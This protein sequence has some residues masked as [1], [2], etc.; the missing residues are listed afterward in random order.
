M[1]RRTHQCKACDS[2]AEFDIDLYVRSVELGGRSME[3]N[4]ESTMRCCNNHRQ[5]ME[6]VL[7]H[8]SNRSLFDAM[9]KAEGLPPADWKTAK[10]VFKPIP[11]E[12]SVLHIDTTQLIPQCDFGDEKARCV[13][14]AKYQIALRCFRIGSK[15]DHADILI[16]KCTCE[17]H[18]RVLK[19]EHILADNASK[20]VVLV[21][22]TNRG[23]PMPDFKR[24]E[25]TFHIMSRGRKI[26]PAQFERGKA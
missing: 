3:F 17:Q 10:A 7:L 15:K 4:A 21:A 26:D 6:A 5:K 12:R 11:I 16:D 19:A 20:S 1:T 25:I 24:T 8:E 2:P 22:L 14:P 13:M 23:F 18:R 9:M